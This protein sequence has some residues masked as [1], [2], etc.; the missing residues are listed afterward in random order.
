MRNKNKLELKAKLFAQKYIDNKFNG[1][2]TALELYNTTDKNTAH[3]IASENLHKPTFTKA[4]VERMRELG[5]DEDTITSIHKRNLIQQKNI[6]A[7][8]T[9][10]DMYYKLKGEYAPDK[11]LN[12]HIPIDRVDEYIQQLLLEYKQLDKE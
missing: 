7:S 11:K 5:M 4:I 3:A 2:K 1:T 9:A 12:I 6:P 10:L 8:N